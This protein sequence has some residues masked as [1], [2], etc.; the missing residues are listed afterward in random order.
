MLKLRAM[1]RIPL[2]G[3]LLLALLATGGAVLVVLFGPSN[4]N[5]LSAALDG[6]GVW[7]PIAFIVFHVLLSI[8][9]VPRFVMGIAAGLTFGFWAGM[10]WSMVGAMAGAFVGFCLARYVKGD[11]FDVESVPKLGPLLL[12]A[13]SGGWRSVMVARFV[14]LIP[15][16][17]LNYALGITR[18]RM[19]EYL[20]GTFVGLLPS[21][22]AYTEFGASSRD[23]LIGRPG[24]MLPLVGSVLL[25]VASFALPKL[26]K[27]W[28]GP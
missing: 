16:P 10:L 13:E 27:R 24:W 4:T 21:G 28:I 9:F 3:R 6:Y 22:I 7:A 17:I 8:G 26:A 15:H 11:S 19:S 5:S 14:P 2:W 1:I 23:A 18:V 12:R 25:L 20:I